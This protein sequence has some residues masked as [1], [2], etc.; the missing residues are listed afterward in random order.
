MQSVQQSG[1]SLCFV[2]D[3]FTLMSTS[4]PLRYLQRCW[5]GV[6]QSHGNLKTV[7]GRTEASF[8]R[9]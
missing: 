9:A 7:L 6:A 2:W 8:L 4:S 1:S 5:G 3:M